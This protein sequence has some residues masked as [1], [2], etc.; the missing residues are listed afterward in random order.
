MTKGTLSD[1]IAAAI[2]AGSSNG[3]PDLIREAEAA[4]L[5][6]VEDHER[7]RQRALDPL[8]S[9][10]EIAEARK[11]M[12][13]AEF[14]RER[15][16]R[17]ADVLR[18]KLV[19]F[20][21]AEDQAERLKVYQDAIARRDATAK[22]LRE[23]YVPLA[24]ELGALMQAVQEAEQVVANA[25][26]RAPRGCSQISGV[27]ETARS[28]LKHNVSAGHKLLTK[29][30]NL[31]ALDPDRG[32]SPIYGSHRSASAI[33]YVTSFLAEVLSTESDGR[34][35][36]SGNAGGSDAALLSHPPSGDSP[37]SSKEAA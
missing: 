35:V 21:E 17:A 8:L 5:A 20:E 3:I 7:A 12:E 36:P 32:H 10:G 29:A 13:D 37:S 2:K 26:R 15:M 27:E 14:I 33:G 1:R 25:N 19:E 6:T 9:D 30:V 11:A 31:P 23:R 24:N 4:A 16:N 34:G 28:G 22:L 18:D